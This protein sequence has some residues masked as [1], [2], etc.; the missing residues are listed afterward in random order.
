MATKHLNEHGEVIAVE[1][2]L[3]A[4]EKALYDATIKVDVHVP[5]S[6]D[7]YAVPIKT[8]IEGSDDKKI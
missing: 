3:E 7:P 8:I 1:V 4:L 6:D 5:R 2:T